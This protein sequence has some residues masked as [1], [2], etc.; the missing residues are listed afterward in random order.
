M[1]TKEVLDF[2]NI[3]FYVSTQVGKTPYFLGGDEMEE[4]F[5]F[6]RTVDDIDEEVLPLI[7]HYLNGNPFPVD[8]D[9]T[10]TT[11]ERVEV[12]LAGVTFISMHTGNMDMMV[13]LQHFKTIVLA[14]RNFLSNY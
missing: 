4:L 10:V 13:P 9:L 5:L 7:D 3:S 8:N 2:Y 14:W 11:R 1:T 12:T 6:F